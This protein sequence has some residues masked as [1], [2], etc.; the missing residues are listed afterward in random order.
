MIE[1]KGTVLEAGLESIER[2]GDQVAETNASALTE[3]ASLL[4]NSTS[5]IDK[6]RLDH[7]P[8]HGAAY[9]TLPRTHQGSHP[10][11]FIARRRAAR[12]QTA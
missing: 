7:L 9:S 2:V 1:C 5:N 6:S 3:A 12:G 10:P 4:F 11:T 8:S